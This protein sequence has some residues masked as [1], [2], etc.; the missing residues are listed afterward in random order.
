MKV[1]LENIGPL[2]QA[3]FEVGDMTIICGDNN[4]GKTYATYAFY[5][6]L[7]FWEEGFSINVSDETIKHLVDNGV[8]HLPVH[9][10]V[11]NYHRILARASMQYTRSLPR[12]FASPRERFEDAKFDIILDKDE[13]KPRSEYE[14]VLRT[15][16]QEVISISKERNSDYVEINLLTKQPEQLLPRFILRRMIGEAIKEVI[17][18]GVFPHPFIASAERTGAAIFRKEL[19]FARNRL[20]EQMSSMERKL[21]P[22]KL[23]DKVY[24]DYA[25]PVRR[26]VDFTRQL[27]DIAKEESFISKEHPDLLTWFEHIIGGTYK[28]VRNS[29]YYVPKK[30]RVRLTMDESSSAVRSLLDIGFYLRHVAK[31]GDILMID[32]PELNL[33]PRNQCRLARL[34]V[35]LINLGV[36]VFMTTHSDYIIKELNTLIM[37]NHDKPH[38]KRVMAREGY[39][40]EELLSSD[41]VKVYIAER[42]LV[43]L[44]GKQRRT[45]LLTLVPADIDPEMGIEARSF[46]KTIEEM[47]RIQE[48]IL[49]GPELDQ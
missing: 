36:K 12:V 35:R 8:V 4:T 31:P 17:F 49:F 27:E 44:P 22:F 38:L 41:R 47:N 37:L 21:D 9:Q 3:E 24:S 42:A 5:G 18:G 16:K 19:D 11:G 28:I 33:H 20:L 7:L 1:R 43:K 29:L 23:L 32:E 30:G 46:D 14:Q 48:E 45:R 25:L 2:R 6:F 39:R 40:Q 34:F 15:T 10:Y 13:I 26:N